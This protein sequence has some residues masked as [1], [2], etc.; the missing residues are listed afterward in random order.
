MTRYRVIESN[1]WYLDCVDEEESL[2]L[3]QACKLCP[4]STS[5]THSVKDSGKI[6]EERAE[7]EAYALLYHQEE[8]H[9]ISMSDL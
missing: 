5:T 4:W 1:L 9:G 6:I 7:L 8:T 3:I 2:T